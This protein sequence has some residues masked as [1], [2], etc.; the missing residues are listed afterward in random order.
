MHDTT[1]EFELSNDPVGIRALAEHDGAPLPPATAPVPLPTPLAPPT[2]PIMFVL[3][4]LT[5]PPLPL[6]ARRPLPSTRIGTEDMVGFVEIEAPLAP[7]EKLAPCPP[8]AGV[9]G[10][11]FVAV[12][13]LMLFLPAAEVDD[14][15]NDGFVST[16]MSISSKRCASTP[17][18]GRPGGGGEDES[19]AEGRRGDG[20][21][22]CP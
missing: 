12:V 7:D 2:K 8:A 6:P 15:D 19:G 1:K 4:P 20:G 10:E 21:A 5:P 13:P 11:D 17:T 22:L 18:G 9:R 3:L 16:A 14:D